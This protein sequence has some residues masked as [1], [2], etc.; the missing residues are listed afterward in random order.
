MKRWPPKASEIQR[1]RHKKGWNGWDQVAAI[2]FSLWI[3]C[4]VWAASWIFFSS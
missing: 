4:M 3:A 1:R 2:S